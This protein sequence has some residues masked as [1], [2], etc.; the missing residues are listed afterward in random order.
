[1]RSIMGISIRQM[2]AV[3]A[4][5]G[6]GVAQAESVR[7]VPPAQGE[8]GTTLELVVEAATTTPTITAH[9]RTTGTAAFSTIELVKR[10]DERWVAVV[11]AV[12]VAAPGI[13]YFL[14]ADGQPVFASEQW[15][16]TLPV[17][18]TAENQRIAR[19]LI[20]SGG[21]RYRIAPRSSGSTT[22]RA[23][24]APTTS[25]IATT[26]STPTSATGCG[27]IRSRSCASATRGCSATRRR[28]TP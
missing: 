22:A 6:G 9:Y 27:C 28:P 15:P 5:V 7:H 3:I 17:N 16:H 19:D 12:A 1:M 10:D 14:V 8:A 2:V 25:R 4:L 18:V 13:D 11:P 26:G 21:R 20:R 24:S 23:R